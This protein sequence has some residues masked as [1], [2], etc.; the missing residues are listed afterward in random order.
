MTCPRRA[1]SA[2]CSSC[3]RKRVN[4]VP[5]RACLHVECASLQL[6]FWLELRSAELV[7]SCLLVKW[8]TRLPLQ[9]SA[10]LQTNQSAQLSRNENIRE[11]REWLN[12]W[13]TVCRGCGP[14]GRRVTWYFFGTLL[15]M[16]CFF[17]VFGARAHAFLR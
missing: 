2:T 14:L 3:C 4:S 17:F 5:H 13:L 11:Q 9:L 6:V 1:G 10:S 16:S 8:Q 7:G 15:V 12:S